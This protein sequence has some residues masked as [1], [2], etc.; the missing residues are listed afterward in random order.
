M[1]DERRKTKD[2]PLNPFH[3]IH[4][5]TQ[6]PSTMTTPQNH[7]SRRAAFTLFTKLAVAALLAAPSAFAAT[8]TPD[9]ATEPDK[10]MAAAHEC[11]V[12]K[13][14][15]KAAEH[16]HAAADSVKKESGKI[17]AGSKALRIGPARN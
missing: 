10:S 7:P 8:T 1:K 3:F 11:F 2:Q 17:D 15:D 13:D 5:F 14:T 6:K 12:K 9:F 16:I 4:P